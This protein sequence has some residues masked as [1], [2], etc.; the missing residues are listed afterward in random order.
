M[1]I[2]ICVIHL[3]SIIINMKNTRQRLMEYL[4]I[5]TVA[6]ALELSHA[7]Q[8]TAADIRHH[9][10]ALR[11]EGQVEVV[12]KQRVQG[13]GRPGKLYSLSQRS[14]DDNLDLLA[15]I[16]LNELI[17]SNTSSTDAA[18]KRIAQG[19]IGNPRLQGHLTQRLYNTISRLNQLNYNARWEA[20]SDAPQVVL[21]RCPYAKII[22]N[23]PELCQM[24]KILLNTLLDIPVKQLAKLSKDKR[25][26]TSCLFLVDIK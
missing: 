16:L 17:K 13:R 12:G 11:E 7:L 22:Q 18:L 4:E 21:G 1:Q 23:H 26:A 25:G 8:V 15:E 2:I 19:L 3:Q 14:L 5:R 9:L 20:R 10:T 6:T 24:D